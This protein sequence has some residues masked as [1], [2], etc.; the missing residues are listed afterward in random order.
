MFPP[1]SAPPILRAQDAVVEV[2]CA[3]NFL[4]EICKAK[5]IGKRLVVLLG[6]A[7]QNNYGPVFDEFNR[8]STLFRHSRN[9]L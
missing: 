8:I 5:P 3:R 7:K 1:L 6:S 2:V 9:V 4:G